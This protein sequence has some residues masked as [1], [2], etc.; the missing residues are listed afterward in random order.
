[1]LGGHNTCPIDHRTC[2]MDHRSSFQLLNF[3][4]FK[5]VAIDQNNFRKL[6][7][8]GNYLNRRTESRLK[9]FTLCSEAL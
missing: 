4:D 9:S 5:N 1:M 7:L 6:F 2:P 8:A 3:Y